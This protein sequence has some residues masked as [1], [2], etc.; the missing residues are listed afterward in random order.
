VGGRFIDLLGVD[1][2][3]AL[4]VIELKVSRGYDRVVGQLLR[5]MGWI[6][7]NLAEPSQRVRGIIVANEISEDLRLACH[8]LPHVDLYEYEMAVRLRKLDRVAVGW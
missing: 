7:A 6:E 8:R 2:V 4:V 5:Y 3:G 1:D